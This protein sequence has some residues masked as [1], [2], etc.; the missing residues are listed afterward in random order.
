MTFTPDPHQPRVLVIDDDEVANRLLSSTVEELG[1]E[2]HTCGDF[3]SINARVDRTEPD[4]I[5][6]ALQLPGH[7]GVE[8]LELLAARNSRARIYIISDME[9]SILDSTCKI[10]RQLNLDV[11]QSF[12]KPLLMEEIRV[13]L[14][15]GMDTRS[16]FTSRNFQALLG[17]GEFVIHYHPIIVLSRHRETPIVGF[18]VRPHW[19][20]RSG[21]KI[22][23]SE[24][25]EQIRENDLLQEFNYH[26]MDKALESYC[27]WLGSVTYLGITV[28]MDKSNL[29]D[30]T[31]PNA[32]NSIAEKWGVSK[33]RITIAIE[34]SAMKDGVT[35]ALAVLTRL[36][37]KGFRIAIDT[38]GTDIEELDRLLD[39]PFGELRL[40]RILVNQIGH[41]MEAEFNV[42]TLVSLARKR[43]ISTCAVGVKSPE[44]FTYLQDC[45][46]TTATG[47]LFGES[48]P[49][50]KVEQFIGDELE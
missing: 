11:A 34:Q 33:N 46:C 40:R 36:R 7:D 37:I 27:Q 13:S 22:W 8:V 41:S 2:F 5:F 19:R 49:V 20:A 25:S 24:I 38:M 18:E 47:S 50:Q 1:I 31:W 10:G 4:I 15:S 44:A 29:S 26:L 39:V 17:P 16:R 32:M 12:R 9:Q 14:I 21:L 23:L 42:A 28:S 30:P 48:L 43:D 35:S 45:G 6:V 3:E